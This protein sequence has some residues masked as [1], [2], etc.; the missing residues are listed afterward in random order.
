MHPQTRAVLIGTGH[1]LP[2]RSVSSAEVEAAAGKPPGW[3]VKRVGIESRRVAADDELSWHMGTAAASDA[4]SRA[5]KPA[6][7][8]DLLLVH[9]S[10]SEL[11]YPDVAWFVA[12]DLGVPFIHL[13][14]PRALGRYAGK[15]VELGPEQYEVLDTFYEEANSGGTYRDLPWIIH[16]SYNQRKYGCLSAGLDNIMIDT[17]GHINACPFCRSKGKY[18]LDEK[19]GVGLNEIRQRGCHKFKMRSSPTL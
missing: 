10:A 1:H 4:L 19:S 11:Y 14:E 13:L 12:R 9:S 8:V 6:S 2:Q 18:A 16:T 17:D 3:A 7:A 15:D 5:G